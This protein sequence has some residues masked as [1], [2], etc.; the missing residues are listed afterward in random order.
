MLRLFGKM[1]GRRIN[2]YSLNL[3]DAWRALFQ[4]L[5]EEIVIVDEYGRIR[6]ICEQVAILTGSTPDA[7]MGQ[8]VEVPVPPIFRVGHIVDRSQ[9]SESASVRPMDYSQGYSFPR[10]EEL[11]SNWPS[12]C[13]PSLLTTRRGLSQ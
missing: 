11:K 9:Y 8:S 12:P 5:P 4:V 3:S 1:W 6:Y 7:F 13:R 2:S 10:K